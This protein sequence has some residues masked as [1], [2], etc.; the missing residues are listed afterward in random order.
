MSNSLKMAF[1]AI[2]HQYNSPLF[3]ELTSYFQ[4]VFSA[5]ERDKPKVMKEQKD[6]IEKS[7]TKH[8]GLLV[9]FIFSDGLE[10]SIHTPLL[11]KNNALLTDL[12]RYGAHM[13]ITTTKSWGSGIFS[14]T[15][16]RQKGRVSGVFSDV[17]HQVNIGKLLF[18]PALGFTAKEIAA[19]TIHELGHAFTQFEYISYQV[20]TNYIANQAT[21]R[22]LALD[23]EK[24]KI[25]LI[26]QI[27]DTNSVEFGDKDQLIV[28]HK[29]EVIKTVL[30]SRLV[31]KQCSELA[32]ISADTTG[33]ES[34]SDQFSTR[35][36]GGLHLVSYLNKLHRLVG[37]STLS[38]RKHHHMVSMMYSALFLMGGI[39][40]VTLSS[41]VVAAGSIAFFAAVMALSAI[42]Y[43]DIYDE[44]IDRF[45]RIR[46]DMVDSLK[47]Q[48]V[49]QEERKQIQD[50]IEKIDNI[51]ETMNANKPYL[52]VLWDFVIPSR[53]KRLSQLQFQQRVESMLNNDLYLQSSKLKTLR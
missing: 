29:E 5:R 2:D 41:P 45:K 52:D 32:S 50:N 37:D 42:P 21:R 17:D 38:S 20:S 27:E 35:H 12:D 9:D 40:L 49:L 7:I 11:Y 10:S 28:T 22:L 31:K 24:A 53:R 3:A 6:H 8:T 1:E 33:W 19:A 23:T 46:R 34:L 15:L 4:E 48:N 14:G 39:G 13:D 18:R 47:N 26:N 36:G 16:D 44:P 25:D 43:D 30:L 51:L